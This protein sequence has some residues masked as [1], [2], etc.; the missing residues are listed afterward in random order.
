VTQAAECLFSNHEA[1]SSNPSPTKKEKDSFYL[2]SAL[3]LSAVFSEGLFCWTMTMMTR[4][5]ETQR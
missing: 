1:L 5:S 3:M 2:F 4:R